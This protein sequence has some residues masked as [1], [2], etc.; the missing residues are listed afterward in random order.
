MEYLYGVMMPIFATIFANVDSAVEAMPWIY[1]I[2]LRIFS[3]TLGYNA[4]LFLSW[5]PPF[6]HDVLFIEGTLG[7][8]GESLLPT[9]PERG[10]AFMVGYTIVFFAL[11][12][13]VFRRRDVSF[14]Q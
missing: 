2:Q 5:G 6:A 4:D 12:M 9:T 14:G 7:L 10:L 1:R 8:S 11:T 3:L 13:W